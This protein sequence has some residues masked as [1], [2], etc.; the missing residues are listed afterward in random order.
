MPK[1][2]LQKQPPGGVRQKSC[3]EKF[4][5]VSGKHPWS[6]TF[7]IL[8]AETLYPECFLGNVFKYFSYFKEHLG[9]ATLRL[10]H[11]FETTTLITN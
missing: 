4:E 3:S 8:L 5:K 6:Y 2:E 1:K 9:T 7:L 11:F 10:K